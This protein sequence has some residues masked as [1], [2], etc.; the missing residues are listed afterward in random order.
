MGGT[1]THNTVFPQ[2]AFGW[3]LKVRKRSRVNLCKTL[4]TLDAA[5]AQ[6]A[7]RDRVSTD[8]AFTEQ[9]LFPE[10]HH[11]STDC[12]KYIFGAVILDVISYLVIYLI[13]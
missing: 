1:H 9:H 3:C 10:F 12:S 6:V 4:Q 2:A 7:G 11:Y 5:A 13:R 8:T